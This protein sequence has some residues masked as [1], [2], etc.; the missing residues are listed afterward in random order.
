MLRTLTLPASWRAV[1]DTF[2]PAFRR[3]ST[4]AVF[5]LLATGLVTQAGRRTVVGML[6]GASVAAAV[7]FH[8]ACRFFSCHA[9]DADRLGLALA[10]LVVDRLL[11]QHAAIEVVIDIT[12]RKPTK[13]ASDLRLY[14]KYMFATTAACFG[15]GVPRIDLIG[16]QRVVTGSASR[17][18][19]SAMRRSWKRRLER[20][21]LRRSSSERLSAVS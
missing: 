5:A 11:G 13:Y 14:V 4:F 21:A 20:A 3:S 6:A 19:R 9:W 17:A 18:S 2:R 10:R 7:S 8:T 12:D 1:L 16:G 15:A